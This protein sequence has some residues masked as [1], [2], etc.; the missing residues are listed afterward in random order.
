MNCCS[1]ML[2]MNL[3]LPI[4]IYILEIRIIAM[5]LMTLS[6]ITNECILT[7]FEAKTPQATATVNLTLSH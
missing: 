2:H 4:L 6:E 5:E 7:L 3:R 1:V